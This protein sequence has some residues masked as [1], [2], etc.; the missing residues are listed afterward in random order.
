MEPVLEFKGYHIKEIIY[1]D[2][3]PKEIENKDEKGSSVQRTIEA[4]ITEDKKRANI[5]IKMDV[6]DFKRNRSISVRI[7]GIF[8]INGD[9]SEDEIKR[10]LGINGVAILYPYVRSIISMISSLDS[11][12]AIVIPTIS[13]LEDEN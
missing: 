6:I 9:F 12:S 1:N 4:G 5:N 11:T 2:E 7:G 13:T 3:I 8:N 10:Y